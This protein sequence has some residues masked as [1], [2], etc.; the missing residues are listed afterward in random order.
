MSGSDLVIKR[1]GSHSM[2]FLTKDVSLED[3]T[4]EAEVQRIEGNG[5]TEL[6]VGGEYFVTFGCFV[7]GDHMMGFLGNFKRGRLLSSPEPQPVGPVDY[8]E[9]VHL[10]IEKTGTTVVYYFNHK[11]IFREPNDRMA[12][13]AIALATVGANARFRNIKATGTGGRVLLE[14]LPDL[15]KREE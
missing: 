13:G 15:P 9:W 12:R 3:F 6:H 10:R 7:K 11:E 8:N 14:G 4:F 1:T 2:V 5:Q